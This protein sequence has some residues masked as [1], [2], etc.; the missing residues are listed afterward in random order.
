M[1][2]NYR[3]LIFSVIFTIVGFG[4]WIAYRD[5]EQILA[6]LMQVGWSGFA[7]LCLFSLLNYG[8]RYWRWRLL[9]QYLGD[10]VS[11]FNSLLC[12]ISGYALTTT[13]A[14]VGETIRCLYFK[15]HYQV[16]YGHSLAGILTERTTDAIS[17]MFIA[18]FAFFGFQHL[19]WV[20][21]AF[22]VFIAGVVMLVAKPGWL[23][24]LAEKLR[25]IK[26]ALWHK[27][28][29]LLPVFLQRSATLFSPQPLSVG[30]IIALLA[31]S[32]EAYAFAWLAH[33]LGGP[34]STWMYMSIFAL[35]MVAG[36][37]TFMPGGLGG[38]EAVLYML[39][40]AT[41]MGD[42]EAITATLLCRLATL[43]FAVGLGL[44]SVLWLEK[45][46]MPM[47]ENEVNSGEP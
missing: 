18:G 44:L 30:I 2:N 1:K 31:W 46:H 22:T 3:Y 28:L 21:I 26:V 45:G 36:A 5:Q 41:G 34:A 11:G 7:L 17:S 43:W 27:L 13:P 15:R 29:D 14:K 32:S 39:M 9:L 24:Y 10:H 47:I 40:K 38:A 25:V 16:H 6:A 33:Q 35:A 37:L 4:L 23:T 12:Y 8:L 20:G 42:A 19:G